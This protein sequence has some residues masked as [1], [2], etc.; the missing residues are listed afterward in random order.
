M[1][2]VTKTVTLDAKFN[3]IIKSPFGDIRSGVMV[4]GEVD[5]YAYG[6]KYNS[7]LEAGGK[8]IGQKVRI[9]CSIEL[10]KG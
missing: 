3:G 4:Y 7:I 1:H 8:A 9:A 6:L 5:R 2:G 10:I